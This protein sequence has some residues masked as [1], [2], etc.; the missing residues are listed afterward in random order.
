MSSDAGM[1]LSNGHSRDI[2]C[3]ISIAPIRAGRRHHRRR[4]IQRSRG[5]SHCCRADT[6]QNSKGFAGTRLAAVPAGKNRDASYFDGGRS[7]QLERSWTVLGARSPRSTAT[8]LG[9]SSESR[10]Q[11]VV[12][13]LPEPDSEHNIQIVTCRSPSTRHRCPRPS[14]GYPRARRQLAELHSYHSTEIALCLPVLQMTKAPA[15]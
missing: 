7:A 6:G 1:A 12:S 11:S 3:P 2:E 14:D 4:G 15:L 13:R 9:Y 5:D 10:P 8:P